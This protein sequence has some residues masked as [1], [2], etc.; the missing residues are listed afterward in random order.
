MCNY[1]EGG[2]G[3]LST[4]K[5][6]ALNGAAQWRN[7]GPQAEVIRNLTRTHSPMLLGGVML[8]LIHA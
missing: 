8:Y 1:P 3:L 4:R 6:P 5:K 2:L 7:W